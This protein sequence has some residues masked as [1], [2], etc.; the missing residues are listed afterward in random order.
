MVAGEVLRGHVTPHAAWDPLLVSAAGAI[1]PFSG[2]ALSPDGKRVAVLSG[3]PGSGQ[4]S[5]VVI[6]DGATGNGRSI[7]F[8]GESNGP[9][10][11][12]DDTSLLLEMT[13]DGGGPAFLR[14]DLTGGQTDSLAASGRGPAFSADRS[15]VAVAADEL[16]VLPTRAWLVG[17]TGTAEVIS[18]LGGGVIDLALD[19]DGGR[20]AV[21]RED[22][23]GAGATIF[24][25]DG[26][27]DGWVVVSTLRLSGDGP[28]A[29]A[30]LDQ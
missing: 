2:P 24:V 9:P 20:L 23:T 27:G 18:S 5:A 26:S 16:L 14:L 28:V 3:M 13:T 25:Y 17:A 29:L 15:F 10:Q 22:S 4:P 6:A 7:P 12:L 21:A 1:G 30:W 8:P 19:A 11:W